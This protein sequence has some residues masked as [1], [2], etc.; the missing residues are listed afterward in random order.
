MTDHGNELCCYSCL[1]KVLDGKEGILSFPIVW[2]S[3][4]GLT[5]LFAHHAAQAISPTLRYLLLGVNPFQN[6]D[7]SGRKPRSRNTYSYLHA[8]GSVVSPTC[9]ITVN[10]SLRE[11]TIR[12]TEPVRSARHINDAHSNSSA[13]CPFILSPVG[14]ERDDDM[15]GISAPVFPIPPVSLH[16]SIGGDLNHWS[17]PSDF[18]AM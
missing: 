13:D 9:P 6:K 8:Q 12:Q 16:H 7:I 1:V 5:L 2:M 11:I 17:Q 14:L 3:D 10:F 15:Y 18:K 4:A